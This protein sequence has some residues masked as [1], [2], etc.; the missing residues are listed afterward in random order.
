MVSDRSLKVSIDSSDDFD[1]TLKNTVIGMIGIPVSERLIA[2][3]AT[4]GVGIDSPV[5]FYKNNENRKSG[6]ETAHH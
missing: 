4:T 5:D 2:D 3:F 6:L 1:E